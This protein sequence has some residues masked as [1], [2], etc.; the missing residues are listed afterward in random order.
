MKLKLLTLL[1]FISGCTLAQQIFVEVGRNTSSF[2]FKNN[3]GEELDNLQSKSQAYIGG[4][5]KHQLFTEK[6]N[7]TT[8]LFYN[9]YGAIGSDESVNNFFEWDI[10]YLGLQAGLEYS[11]FGNEF[12]E[13]YIMGTVAAEWM[14]EGVQTINNT[15]LNVK[16]VEEFDDIAMFF[17]SGGGLRFTISEKAKAYAQY[18]YGSGLA[19][20]DNNNSSTTELRINVHSIGIG[21]LIEIPSKKEEEV[22]PEN[23][24]NETEN[25]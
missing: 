5:F 25:K 12:Y 22:L 21:I 24:T 13:F 3:Q 10:D 16:D 23:D 17:R 14:V 6:L 15:V 9:S 7:L 1:L 20:D 8:G 11:L 2:E 4:G 19:L 18:L